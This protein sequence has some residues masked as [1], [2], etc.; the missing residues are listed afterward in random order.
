MSYYLLLACS[1]D[2]RWYNGINIGRKE[3]VLEKNKLP[4]LLQFAKR[5]IR[6]KETEAEDE[7]NDRKCVCGL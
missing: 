1:A 3:T 2:C 4:D 6:N 7:V 5:S